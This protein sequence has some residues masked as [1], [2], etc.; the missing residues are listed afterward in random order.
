MSAR[1][2]QK[3]RA[4]DWERLE[5]CSPPEPSRDLIDAF[6]Q[7]G[8]A[9][10]PAPQTKQDAVASAASPDGGPAPR[11]RRGLVPR[12]GGQFEFKLQVYL[13]PAEGEFFREDCQRQGLSMTEVAARVMTDHIRSVRHARG[14][15]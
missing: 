8:D 13:P 4:R 9:K 7:T 2:R 11:R 15:G 14:A 3:G 5:V 12:A 1:G 10:V 6:V